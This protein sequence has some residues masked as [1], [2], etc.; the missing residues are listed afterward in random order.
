MRQVGVK[1]IVAHSPEAKGRVERI[2][3]TLQNRLV[4]ELRWN[5]ISSQEEANK[6]LQETFIPKFNSQFAVVPNRK[7]D[8]HKKISPELK[9]KGQ[10][11][12]KQIFSIQDTRVVMNDY[13][14]RFENKFFQ[15]DKVQPTTV[16]KKDKVIVEEHL[17]GSLKIRIRDSYLNYTQLPKRPE[18]VINV[19]LPALTR[20]EQR[21]YKPPKDHPWRRPFLFG[22]RVNRLN[23]NDNNNNK[24]LIHRQKVL[25]K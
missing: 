23:N 22:K 20:D 18:K 5:K 16:Y 12:L 4:K 14:I 21:S 10:L 15:L 9:E 3:G 25:T 8:L 19:K 24:N 13:T 1:T 7:Q 17:D 11:K 6:Y 2:F